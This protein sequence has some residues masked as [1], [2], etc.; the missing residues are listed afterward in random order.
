MGML[1]HTQL[2]SIVIAGALAFAIPTA[3][4]H[5][6]GAVDYDAL[7]KAVVEVESG[8][9]P[10]A[11]GLAGE[12]GLMQI[13]SGTW[14]DMSR[15]AFGESVDFS[16]AFDPELNKAV[17]RSYL[18]YLAAQV[19]TASH[20]SHDRLIRLVAASYNG[21]PALVRM[22]GMSTHRLSAH[23]R[24]YSERVTSLY[25]IY[26]ADSP[27][28]PTHDPVKLMAYAAPATLAPEMED[29]GEATAHGRT[30]TGT[31][32]LD[33]TSGPIIAF[34]RNAFAM[35]PFAMVCAFCVLFQDRRIVE[36]LQGEVDTR[37]RMTSR[38]VEPR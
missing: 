12:R 5:H 9:N 31:A 2:G 15:R 33:S 8:G 3:H 10:F 16:R 21:G 23:V 36:R 27:A 6:A 37:A 35:M 26:R 11:V 19:D 17:G 25:S 32:D 38:L 7:V 30:D 14:S 34:F 13:K 24:S 1:K 18:E 4:A 20:G 29:G 22:R 28:F